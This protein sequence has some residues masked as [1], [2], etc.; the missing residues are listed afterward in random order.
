[1]LKLNGKILKMSSNVNQLI[2]N[3]L[4]NVCETNLIMLAHL[5]EKG[6]AEIVF[7]NQDS[8][9]YKFLE[10]EAEKDGLKK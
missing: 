2:L 4:N 1:M 3:T 5:L 6:D 7:H 9:W 8:S 10:K